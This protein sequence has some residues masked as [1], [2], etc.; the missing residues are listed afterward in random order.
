MWLYPLPPI[1]AAAGFLFVLFSRKDAAREIRYG[2]AIAIS[3]CLLY[4]IRA[5]IR[6]EWPFVLGKSKTN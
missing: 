3:G 5:R 1:L 6:R 4:F 2:A